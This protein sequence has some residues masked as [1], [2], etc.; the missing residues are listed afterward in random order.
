MDDKIQ[1]KIKAQEWVV[2]FDGQIKR[3][4]KEI[5]AQEHKWEVDRQ[6]NEQ[7]PNFVFTGQKIIFFLLVA[8]N[9]PFGE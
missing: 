5:D 8:T 3:S 1:Q 6:K 7:K 9:C 2:M 4:E